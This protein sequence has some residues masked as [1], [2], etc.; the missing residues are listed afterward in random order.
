MGSRLSLAAQLIALL[1]VSG[2]LTILVVCSPL[3][4]L[5][6]TQLILF[7]A[8][9]TVQPSGREPADFGFWAQP[10]AIPSVVFLAIVALGAVWLCL[11]NAAKMYERKRKW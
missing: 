7:G 1:A 6:F 11:Y 10:Y 9:I 3:Y 4:W 8:P 2:A 5:A